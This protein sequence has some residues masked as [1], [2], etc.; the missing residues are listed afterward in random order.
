MIMSVSIFSINKGILKEISEQQ[1]ELEKD[2]QKIVENNMYTIFGIDFVASEFEL[3]G[4]RVDSLG[5]DKNESNSFTIIEYKRDKSFSVI[6]QGYAYL[7]LLVNNQAEFILLYNEKNKNP[8]RKEDVDWSQSRV[9]FISPFFTTYQRKAI[10]FKDLPIELWEAR[11]YSNNTILF[12]QIK[13]PEKSE[14]IT[15]ISQKSALVRSVNQ[16]VRVYNEDHHFEGCSEKIHNLYKDLKEGI[17]SIS[18][19]VT[20]KPKA[21]YIAFIHKRNFLAIVVR[22][23]NLTLFLNMKKGSLNDS[24]AVARDVSNV[25]HWGNGDYEIIIREPSDIGYT[26]TLIKQ[27]YESN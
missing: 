8:L 21:K 27:S 6:D 11:L 2:I 5:Y 24:K 15:K 19:D 10:E 14:S 25:G 1:I 26:L 3:N 22:K 9:I 20:I 7:G 17:I 4:L 16:Q 18:T 13:S 23:S 12:N